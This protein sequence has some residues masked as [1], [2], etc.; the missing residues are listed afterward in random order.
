[1]KTY[2][3]AITFV[4][5]LIPKKTEN[6]PYPARRGLM[7]MKKLLTYL[8][9]PHLGYP[10]VHVG[11]TSGKGSTSFLV[12]QILN[13]SGYKTGLHLSPHLT[14]A[15]ERLVI[16]DRMVPRKEF[17]QLTKTVEP[18]VLRM[19]QES[20]GR[21]SYYEV[22]LAMTF[23]WF[24][25]KSVDVAVVEVG[26]GGRFD[27]TNVLKSDVV[28]LTSIGL[29]HTRVLGNTKKLILKEKMQIIK[30][31]TKFAVS[32]ITK[33]SLKKILKKHTLK[34]GV[35]V[36]FVN[37]NFK[38]KNIKYFQDKT[39][40]DFYSDNLRLKKIHLGLPGTYQVDNSAL[41][42][43][44][45][46]FLKNKM[47]FEKINSKNILASL[48]KLNFPARL[49][50]VSHHPLVLVDGAHNPAKTKALVN[51]I[52]KIYPDKRFVVLFA[53]KKNKK[54]LKMLKFLEPHVEYLVVT[55]FFKKI[56]LGP[57]LSVE[58]K[59]L[60]EIALSYF[61]KNQVFAFPDSKKALDKSLNLAKKH[62][63]PIL[64]TGSFYL[65]GELMHYLKS[66]NE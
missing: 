61:D 8:K 20:L 13:R 32:A 29:D 45:A 48:K 19:S 37:T 38:T 46:W 55:E 15:R 60:E 17:V 12:S 27:G 43:R 47:G 57:K 22:L 59:K 64:I 35:P 30:K 18:I 36:E 25:K 2:K 31:S 1:M 53:I 40:F 49:Q 33:K 21:P 51:S 14:T 5:G 24:F 52:K 34:K 66:I 42:I 65:I 16:N 26:M 9:N 58:T 41:A 11:G 62:Q 39:V 23:L 56:D 50:K 44:T 6:N 7:R 63:L 54:T 4:N 10:V 3:E 28:I